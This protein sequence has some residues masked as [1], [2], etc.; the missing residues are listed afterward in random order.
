MK[1]AGGSRKKI[2][3]R[4]LTSARIVRLVGRR[5]Q[6]DRARCRPPCTAPPSFDR[7]KDEI[8]PDERTAAD[9]FG[10]DG[11]VVSRFERA[12]N[13][14]TGDSLDLH[15]DANFVELLLRSSAIFS[16]VA[17][18]SSVRH[19]K[20]NRLGMWPASRVLFGRRPAASSRSVAASIFWRVALLRGA[21]RPV[22]RPDWPVRHYPLPV[23]ALIDDRL[24]ID[25]IAQ[26]LTNARVL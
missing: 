15:V 25:G 12:P 18:F 16:N 22:V 5:A 9:A 24:S 7:V 19:L 3:C 1:M 26:R 6:A 11:V 21:V 8:G 14:S 13:S 2:C 20:R 17:F 10:Q 23:Q 4:S